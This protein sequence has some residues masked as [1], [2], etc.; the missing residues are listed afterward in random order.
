V[1]SRLILSGIMKEL[2]TANSFI[3]RIYRIDTEDPRKLTGLAEA[4][5][6]SGERAPFN[7]IDELASLLSAWSVKPLKKR[8]RKNTSN[9]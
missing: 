7:H 2:S 3:V 9:R 6:G 8:E 1:G 4:M 5:D